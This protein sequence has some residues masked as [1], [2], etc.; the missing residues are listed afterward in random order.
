MPRAAS[1]TPRIAPGTASTRF[2]TISSRTIRARVAPS[3]RRSAISPWRDIPRTS[4]SP[5]MFAHAMTR[6]S[7]PIAATTASVGS[8]VDGRAAGRLPERNDS[9]AIGRFGERSIA[10]ERGTKRVDLRGGAGE[11]RAGPEITLRIED[12]RAPIRQDA[13]RGRLRAS[14]IE[15]ELRRH[16]HRNVELDVVDD[17]R[18]AAK[19]GIGDAD[20]RHRESC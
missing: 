19:R 7:R 3:A 6:T 12:G 16:H 1:T 2:S 5:A 20:D 14:E 10:R 8:T 11:R 15:P 17:G 9:H 13:R 18:A 4:T